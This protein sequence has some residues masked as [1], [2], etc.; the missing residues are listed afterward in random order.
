MSYRI[1]HIGEKRQA[2]ILL[3]KDYEVESNAINTILSEQKQGNG[4]RY[5]K[6]L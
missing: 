4:T 3:Y 6:K 5:N 1:M 2:T